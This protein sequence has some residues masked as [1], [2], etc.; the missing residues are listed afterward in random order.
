MNKKIRVSTILKR[1]KEGVK[2]T[3][4]TAYDYTFA[5][6]IDEAGV[7][8]ILVGDSCG[9]VCAGYETTLPVTVDEL[10]Y[11]ARSVRR[12][13]KRA[14]LVADMPFM[15]Y[16]ENTEQALHNAGRFMKETGA[17]AVKMEGGRHICGTVRKMVDIGIPVMGHLGFT[18]QSVHGFGGYKVR[19]EDS[20]EAEKIRTDAL[21]LQDA[22]VFSIVLEKVPAGL[23][24]EISGMLEI[25]TIG[26]GAGPHCDG[27]I[28][29]S[30]DLIGLYDKVRFKFV[31]QYAR[32]AEDVRNAVVA[33]CKDVR[34]EQF[35]AEDESY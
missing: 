30:Y 19:G 9:N 25:P 4:L 11:H 13:V 16:Q 3:A 34:D 14:L 17:E 33:Y 32:L 23:A 7:D 27:Q 1:K 6:L 12:G 29:V 21:A 35:P 5:Y 20:G 28:L 24:K 26:I 31:R 8:I 18:P 15:S 10:I 2:I 22:G